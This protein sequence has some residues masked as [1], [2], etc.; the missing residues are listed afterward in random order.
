MKIFI[1]TA[2]LDEIK[3][4]ESYGILDGVTTNPS[5]MKK[6]VAKLKKSGKKIDMNEYIRK[7]LK[8]AKKTP[9]SL[10]VVG[11]TYKDMLAEGKKLYSKFKKDGNVV[12][13]IPINPVYGK[14]TNNF[15][16]IKVIKELSK[17]KIPVNCTLVFT[18]EQCLLA[19]KAGATYIS[20]F[21]GRIDDD[22]RNEN[23]YE[24][25]KTDYYPS[26]GAED[27]T[28]VLEDNGIISGIDLV[29]QCM[30]VLDTYGYDTEIIAASIR[31]SRQARECALV[32]ADIVTLPFS[33][34]Q[35]M[36]K[37]Y[38]TEEGMTAFCKDVVPEY[39]AVLK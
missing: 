10:E 28:D 20:P 39:R 14:A 37:H 29:S 21:A 11:V 6:A 5:L 27:G 16:G 18:P 23:G 13:K 7:I 36:I 3:E 31:N 15:D 4:A 26:G 8:A 30:E 22:L 25:D 35:G 9:V 2:D 12:I 24:F 19:A 38:K 17:L 32:G 33:I 34:I 1:D